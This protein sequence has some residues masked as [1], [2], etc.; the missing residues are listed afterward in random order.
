MKPLKDFYAGKV[1]LVTG[2]AGSIGS[3]IV[4]KLLEYKP[5]VVR[6]FDN[7]ETGLFEL[8]QE[9][10]KENLR[11]LV[12]D[13][14][15]KE[16]CK[17]A[18]EDVDIVFH[19]AALKHVPL[20]EYNP[21]EAV[22]TNIIGTQNL[23][24]VAIDEEVEKFFAISTDKAVNP[25]NV[26]GATKLLSERLTVSANFYK[27]ERKSVFSCVRFGNVLGSSG[28]VVPIFKEQIKAGGPVT[29]TNKNMTRFVM[30]IS[31]AANLILKAAEM[32]Q[33]GEVFILKMPSIK[34]IDLAAVMIQELASKNGYDPKHIDLKIIGNRAGEKLYE[35]LLTEDEAVMTHEKNELLIM[36]SRLTTQNNGHLGKKLQ[37]YTSNNARLLTKA[38]IDRLLIEAKLV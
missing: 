37:I 32:A 34:I 16:R 3:A 2:G 14:R 23:I 38:E 21:F 6:V 27:G 4:K 10:Q 29:L 25:A 35:E 36:T 7:N 33:G 17:R 20:C 15:D 13:I 8:Q 30:S 1:I 31:E 9:L 18:I 5:K 22:K 24:D 12:G 19:S 28:S 26:M 11:M